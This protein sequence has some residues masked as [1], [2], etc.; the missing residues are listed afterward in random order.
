MNA[1]VC[2]Q[3]LE[4]A[5]RCLR[6]GQREIGVAYFLAAEAVLVRVVDPLQYLAL[7]LQAD[8]LVRRHLLPEWRV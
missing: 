7:T 4:A 6:D 3:C 1:I 2:T 5:Q 8:V